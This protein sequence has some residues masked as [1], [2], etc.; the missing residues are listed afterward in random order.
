M[1]TKK[2]LATPEQMATAE[3][4]TRTILTASRVLC[5]EAQYAA[6]L[7]LLRSTGRHHAVIDVANK[8]GGYQKIVPHTDEEMRHHD[9]RGQV[10]VLAST[11]FGRELSL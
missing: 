3:R 8:K 7:A 1:A 2:T 6:A 5:T 9:C 11:K 10:T 4:V